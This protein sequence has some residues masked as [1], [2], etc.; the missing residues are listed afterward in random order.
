MEKII[1]WNST[2]LRN[3]QG[4]VRGTMSIG[5]DITERYA[6]EK[7]KGEFI[8]IAS[9]E[10]R[11]PLTSIHG[12]IQLL[13]AER[14]G[15]LSAKGKE[16]IKIANKNTNRLIL[17]LNDVLDLE[18]ME[19]QKD[20]I[21][22]QCCNSAE[23]IRQAIE[24][25]NYM[26]QKH[27]VVIETNSESIELWVDPDRILQTLTNLISNAI[28]F[29]NVGDIIWI[30]SQQQNKEVLFSVKDQGRG[31]PSDQQENI[32]E[33][34]HQVDATDSRKKG[35]TGLGLAICRSIVEKH[36]GKIWVESV[37]GQ[38]SSFYFKL[39]IRAAEFKK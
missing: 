26:A 3:P 8:S 37:F 6:I 5:L 20:Q 1:A 10:M 2:L 28:K 22:R 4:E 12:V 25:V 30:T 32:F 35:G 38:G 39:P 14:L 27:Q 11:T 29:S 34:F 13:E 7:I 23:L 24:T 19:S 33:R 17:L 31:I 21:E 9:H 15:S 16:M 36:G 18:R